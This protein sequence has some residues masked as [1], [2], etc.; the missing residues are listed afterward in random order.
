MFSGESR[1]DDDDD[2]DD[3]V[4]IVTLF[5][6]FNLVSSLTKDN[7]NEVPLPTVFARAP[8]VSKPRLH[9]GKRLRLLGPGEA[10]ENEI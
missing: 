10:A 9:S 5:F 1:R 2:D 8:F 6:S 7:K 4:K 3:D